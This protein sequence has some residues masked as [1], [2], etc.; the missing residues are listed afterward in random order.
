MKTVIISA[1]AFTAFATATLAEESKFAGKYFNPYAEIGTTFEGGQYQDNV[2]L[3]V[4]VDGRV[5]SSDAFGEFNVNVGTDTMDYT[6]TTGIS[7][8]I[9]DEKLAVGASVSYGWGDTDGTSMLGFG[10]DNEWG[11]T[12]ITPKLTYSPKAIGGEYAFVSHEFAMN[13]IADYQSNGSELGLGYTHDMGNV[14]LNGEV[15]WGVNND[16]EFVNEADVKVGVGFKF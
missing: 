12:T 9:I 11:T 5:A 10:A 8:D 16:L 7:R 1:V 6:L 15:T 2:D 13:N 3:T 4:G 14:Y